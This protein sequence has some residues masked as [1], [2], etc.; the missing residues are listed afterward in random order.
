MTKEMK[1]ILFREL[2]QK[3]Y[4]VVCIADQIRCEI[5][6]GD[7]SLDTILKLSNDIVDLSDL[8]DEFEKDVI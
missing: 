4:D 1:E 6:S 7:Q 5:V 2:Q 8:H 3:M